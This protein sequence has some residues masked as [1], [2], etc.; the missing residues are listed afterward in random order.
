MEVEGILP[1]LIS[2]VKH[3]LKGDIQNISDES[4]T[5]VKQCRIKMK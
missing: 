4:D 1:P 3:I 2:F 5:K